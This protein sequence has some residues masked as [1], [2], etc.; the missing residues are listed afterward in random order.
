[1]TRP[2][3]A[4]ITVSKPSEFIL[5]PF[6]KDPIKTALT[7]VNAVYLY[8]A[9]AMIQG[10]PADDYSSGTAGA[11]YLL[12]VMPSAD[13]LPYTFAFSC[14][15]STTVTRTYYTSPDAA[16]SGATYTQIGTATGSTGS[17][18]VVEDGG[19]TIPAAT[20]HVKIVVSSA[21][22]IYPQALCIYPTP[23]ATVPATT[24]AG[25]VAYDDGLLDAA[26][27]APIHSEFLDRCRKSS[28]AVFHDRKQCGL[29]LF[30]NTDPDEDEDEEHAIAIDA[31]GDVSMPESRIRLPGCVQPIKL[32]IKAIGVSA[33][34]DVANGI[35]VTV[36]GSSVEKV[37]LSITGEVETGSLTVT[38]TGD[39][40]ERFVD[41]SLYLSSGALDPAFE[42]HSLIIWPEAP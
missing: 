37:Q 16:L 40:L 17:D 39:G 20:R 34:A 14:T 22:P 1:M 4:S 15:A 27:G 36:K 8:H 28:L 25:F 42:L 31:G 21:S 13:G 26:A 19:Y 23:S 5:P 9:P 6:A 30:C 3:P 11:T 2:S 18:G 35:T 32:T 12:P 24:S 29:S 10:L 41:V 38:P 33:G 7:N